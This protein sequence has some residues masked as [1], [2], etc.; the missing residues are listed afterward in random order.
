MKKPTA[1]RLRRRYVNAEHPLVVLR[2]E[3]GH[4]IRVVKGQ[5]KEFDAYEGE[6][7][8]VIAIYDPTSGERDVLD[9]CK[10]EAFDPA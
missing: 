10:A 8:K 4:E 6:T 1:N 7:I 3:D 9:S 2:F 5:G